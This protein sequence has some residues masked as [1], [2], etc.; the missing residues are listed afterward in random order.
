LRAHVEVHVFSS[1]YMYRLFFSGEKPMR[2]PLTEYL[3]F[4]L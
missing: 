4:S 1:W 2:A 3:S